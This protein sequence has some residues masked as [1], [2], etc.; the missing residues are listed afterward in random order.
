MANEI[1]NENSFSRSIIWHYLDR[2]K[3]DGKIFGF[4]KIGNCSGKIGC[5]TGS[6]TAFGTHLKFYH[7]REWV[8]YDKKK[9]DEKR[10]NKKF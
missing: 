10:E 6:T 8:E 1:E 9:A 5:P 3:V 4:C 7:R 2:R